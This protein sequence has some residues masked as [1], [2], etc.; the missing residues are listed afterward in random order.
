MIVN[1]AHFFYIL[2]V[3]SLYGF[4]F[5]TLVCAAVVIRFYLTNDPSNYDRCFLY[6]GK[7]SHTRLKGISK[8]VAYI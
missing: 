4:L 3:W 7:V 1:L 5:G 6:M 8:I 2:A